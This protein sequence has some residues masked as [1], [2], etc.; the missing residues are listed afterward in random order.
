MD[1]QNPAVIAYIFRIETSSRAWRYIKY[2]LPRFCPGNDFTAVFI[3]SRISQSSLIH[4][5]SFIECKSKVDEFLAQKYNVLL[6]DVFSK[7]D[8]VMFDSS[9]F[10]LSHEAMGPFDIS[11]L[12]ECLPGNG[13]LETLEMGCCRTLS[14]N[15][16]KTK[17][18]P[19]LLLFP[20]RD[21]NCARIDEEVVS[22]LEKA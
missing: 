6:S 4:S 7:Q 20:V 1:S 17:C 3:I 9:G 19:G 15:V 11:E 22:I 10:C 16:F 5:N 14:H 13:V 21:D 2:S 18:L 12:I 8:F